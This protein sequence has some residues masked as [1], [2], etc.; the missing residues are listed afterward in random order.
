MLIGDQI[1]DIVT[2]RGTIQQ[3]NARNTN[4]RKFI[5]ERIVERKYFYG[6]N[7]RISRWNKENCKIKNG[8]GRTIEKKY[9]YDRQYQS[10]K[11]LIGFHRK[12]KEENPM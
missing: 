6:K 12:E 10:Q 5:K 2:G 3:Y 11:N 7:C 1:T 9:C 4:I 8:S